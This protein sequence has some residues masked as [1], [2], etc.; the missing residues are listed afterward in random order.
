MAAITARAIYGISNE[1][2]TCKA[3]IQS[4]VH[5]GTLSLITNQHKSPCCLNDATDF[6]SQ[7]IVWFNTSY[8]I[9]YSFYFAM[10]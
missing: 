10:I 8:H 6:T 9:I 3:D 7:P 5:V 4:T 1:D 2:V